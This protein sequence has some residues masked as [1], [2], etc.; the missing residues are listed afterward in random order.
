MA[1]LVIDISGASKTFQIPTVRRRTIREH[2]LDLFRARPVEQLHVLRDV[3]VAVR[4]GE[5]VGVMGRNGSGKSTLLKILCGIYQA[6]AGSITVEGEITPVLELGVGFNAELDAIDNIYLLGTVM[7]M[8]LREVDESIDRVLAFA[9]L[10]RFARLRLQHYSSGMTARLAYAVAFRAVRDI[11]VLD[12]IF[13]VGDAAFRARCEERYQALVSAGRTLLLVSHDPELVEQLC[14][15]A[16]LI[17][18]GRIVLEGPADAVAHEYV[19]LLS[20]TP[21]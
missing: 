20:S 2:A 5:S 4:R 14:Q 8:S 18:Q 9:G 10:E 11:V 15:R 6:D 17:D 1:D 21:G 7:G 3:S 13:A 19:R 16:I 12:E